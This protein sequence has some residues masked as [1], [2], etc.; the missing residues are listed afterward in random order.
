MAS[1]SNDTITSRQNGLI[2]RFAK[3]HITETPVCKV[4]KRPFYSKFMFFNKNL[5]GNL[6]S[7]C[8]GWKSMENFSADFSALTG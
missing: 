2:T 5:S 1:F 8:Y 3:Y 4:T 7:L 6:Y